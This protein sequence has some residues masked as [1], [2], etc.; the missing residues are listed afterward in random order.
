[1]VLHREEGSDNR[2]IRIRRK[3]DTSLIQDQKVTLSLAFRIDAE[4][5]TPDY[6]DSAFNVYLERGTSDNLGDENVRLEFTKEGDIKIRSE[7]LS[8]TL[9][10]GQWDDPGQPYY[11]LNTWATLSF[12]VDLATQRASYFVNGEFL[13]DYEFDDLLSAGEKL[14]QIRFKGP[15]AYNGSPNDGVSIDAI[16]LTTVPEPASLALLAMGGLLARRRGRK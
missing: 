4:R 11:A 14:D 8:S 15:R 5:T 2:E 9:T 10:V 6:L 3:Y 12:V 7:E 1:M 16:S 13:G